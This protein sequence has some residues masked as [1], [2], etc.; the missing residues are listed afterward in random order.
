[1]RKVCSLVVVFLVMSFV[2]VGCGGDKNLEYKQINIC[3]Y[4]LGN[5]TVPEKT[6]LAS[7]V[8]ELKRVSISSYENLDEEEVRVIVGAVF[9]MRN[10]KK[11]FKIEL[12]RDKKTISII[13]DE[14]GVLEFSEIADLPL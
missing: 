6:A 4:S 13:L 3:A 2:C 12:N 5:L 1:M 7:S 8:N 11:E 10:V 9:K 14:G